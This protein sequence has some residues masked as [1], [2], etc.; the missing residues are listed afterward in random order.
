[1][2]GLKLI[3]GKVKRIELV[4]MILFFRNVVVGLNELKSVRDGV[5]VWRNKKKR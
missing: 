4:V 2:D 1:L 3:E 5:C